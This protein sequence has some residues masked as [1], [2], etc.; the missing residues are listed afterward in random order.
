[1]QIALFIDLIDV[2][3]GINNV[4]VILIEFSL[5]DVD[6]GITVDLR[7]NQFLP[8]NQYTLSLIILAQVIVYQG[9]TRAT[10]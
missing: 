3:L 8:Y 1:M 4:N 5:R 6:S 10:G 7:R 2:L 9:K